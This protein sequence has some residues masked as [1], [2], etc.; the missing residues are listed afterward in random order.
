MSL[1]KKL[2]AACLEVADLNDT[3]EIMKQKRKP[4]SVADRNAQEHLDEALAENKALRRKATVAQQELVA[5]WE[6][7]EEQQ[8]ELEE[9]KQKNDDLMVDNRALVDES[10]NGMA[11]DMDLEAAHR[12]LRAKEGELEKQ[13]KTITDLEAQL[14]SANS[15]VAFLNDRMELLLN[16]E[17]DKSKASSKKPVNDDNTIAK[18]QGDLLKSNV[19]KANNEL[20]KAQ[21]DLLESRGKNKEQ[22]KQLKELKQKND[23]LI[24]ENRA[25]V[26]VAKDEK[27]VAELRQKDLENNNDSPLQ[28]LKEK[29]VAAT[30]EIAYLTDKVQILE[31]K[32]KR[33]RSA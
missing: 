24:V 6:H 14:E 7:A 12:K 26:D 9:L 2:D 23:E 16:K 17:D 22:K 19:E 29:L 5:A 27:E 30:S 4:N 20:A 3:I 33:D 28:D 32:H 1:Q 13:G 31:Q 10:S 15:E 21:G 11:L 25:L 8:K 18:A